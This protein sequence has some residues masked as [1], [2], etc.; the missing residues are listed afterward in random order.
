MDCLSLPNCA[1]GNICLHREHRRWVGVAGRCGCLPEV[2]RLSPALSDTPASSVHSFLPFRFHTR[3]PDSEYQIFIT[4]KCRGNNTGN[5]HTCGGI[6]APIVTIALHFTTPPLL[7]HRSYSCTAYTRMPSL[8][9]PA[10]RGGG[11]SLRNA[12]LWCLMGISS[13]QPRLICRILNPS[14]RHPVRCLTGCN[15]N[16]PSGSFN[17]RH[18]T[19]PSPRRFLT[20]HFHQPHILQ[21][22]HCRSSDPFPYPSV[23]FSPSSMQ[24]GPGLPTPPSLSV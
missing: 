16:P 23:Q 22:R 15:Q 24:Q 13:W 14:Q 4:G 21:F 20:G 6:F 12:G 3:N 1:F 11:I 5:K 17:R 2:M 8:S 19:V 18:L 7:L 10:I 9:S